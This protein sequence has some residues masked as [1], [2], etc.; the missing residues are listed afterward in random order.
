MNWINFVV[1]VLLVILALTTPSDI[2]V[3]GTKTWRGVLWLLA[4]GNFAVVFT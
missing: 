1:G 3:V 4:I 2:P